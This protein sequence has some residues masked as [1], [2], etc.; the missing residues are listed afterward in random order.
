MRTLPRSLGLGAAVAVVVSNVIG[1]GIFM[2]SGF[3]AQD[4]K[5]PSLLLLIWVLGGGL[6]L[7]GALCY[8]ELG[9]RFP[10][11]GGEYVFLREVYGPLPA[12]LT[13]WASF[14]VGFAA[15]IA[16]S[17]IGFTAHLSY[18]YPALA[19]RAGSRFGLSQVVAVLTIVALSLI[20]RRTAA[21]GA[22]FHVG[23]TV[24]KVTLISLL[25]FGAPAVGSG[26]IAHFR[27][28]APVDWSTALPGLAVG[29]IF[30]MFSYSGWNAAA[31]IG[32]EIKDAS[33]ALPRALLQG[34]LIVI[35][36]YVG[37]NAVY[38]YALP[39]GD[40]M[41]VLKVGERAAHALFLTRAAPF[42][43]LLI[44]ASMLGSV[45]AM[46]IAG[47]RIYFAM[48]RD[49]L[50]VFPK[51]VSRIHPRF[52]TPSTAILLQ[53][54]WASVLAVLG[55][56]E[57]LITFSGVVLLL[58]TAWTISGLF[59][60]RRDPKDRHDGYRTWGYPWTPAAFLL[61]IAWALVYNLFYRTFESLIGLGICA[62]GVPAYYAFKRRGAVSSP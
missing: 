53:A 4:L 28:T 19:P 31:Y 56:F 58:F 33:R 17:A 47:P 8:G 21:V 12:F 7:A 18:F 54:V 13:G 55:G 59:L 44:M 27:E 24:V 35:A 23:V 11:S 41:G 26:A 62:L 49:G 10:R 20:H 6:A 9:A 42:F 2:T 48:A 16:A 1:S 51:A 25:I 45:S 57:Q 22:R 5:S 36:V 38:L 52:E 39:I 40:M 34:T 61:V 29:L 43:S 14:L 3:L 60:L 37:L 32:E 50:F 30:V 46:V 15:P